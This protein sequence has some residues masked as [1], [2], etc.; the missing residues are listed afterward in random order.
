MNIIIKLTTSA[1][2]YDPIRDKLLSDDLILH[3]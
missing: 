1:D 3:Q 2:F